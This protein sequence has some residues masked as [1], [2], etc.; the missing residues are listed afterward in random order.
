MSAQ[1]MTHVISN[2]FLPMTSHERDIQVPPTCSASDPAAAVI[3]PLSLPHP[4]SG[5]F[6]HLHA[7]ATHAQSPA[8]PGPHSETSKPGNRVYSPLSPGARGPL[9]YGPSYPQ[10]RV[11]S[12]TSPVTSAS[13][14]PSQGHGS[15]NGRSASATLAFTG[16][17]PP[18]PAQSDTFGALSHEQIVQ[19]LQ[20]QNAKI[21]EAWEAERK[22]LEANRERAEEVYKEER[23]LMEEERAQWEAERTA[24]IEEIKRLRQALKMAEARSVPPARNMQPATLDPR[25]LSPASY[26]AAAAQRT[27]AFLANGA[28]TRLPKPQY[29]DLASPRS[30][31]GPAA[32]V[33]DFLKPAGTPSGPVPVVD[34]KEIHPDLEG[35]P[36]K[37]TSVKK[38]TFTDSGSSNG[39]RTSSN[40]GSPSSNAERKKA[41]TQE[42]LAAQETERLTMHAGHTPS[43]SLS[44]LQTASSSGTNTP[45][46]G[47]K[48]PTVAQDEPRDCSK[49]AQE[50]ETA[51]APNEQAPP[52][53]DHPEPVLEPS[54]GDREL[55]G[56][57]MVRNMPAHDEIFFQALNSKLEEVSKDRNAAVPTVLA[58]TV[59]SRSRQHDGASGSDLG[60]DGRSTPRSGD[61]E[62]L[63]VPIKFRRRLNFGA[64]FGEIR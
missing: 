42:V 16:H 26:A 27:A 10:V 6:G 59:R 46:G 18:P 17:P 49:D 57:L 60:S 48:T 38:A 15:T 40:S 20:Q 41:Q 51:P 31:N 39:T 4:V 55:K 54:D 19:R 14:P 64:P 33:S 47:S 44:T 37:A 32:P 13:G 29:L 5:Y 11:S 22:Y 12:I 56:P 43:H 61:E 28:P 1:T 52:A 9:P 25:V 34:V 21:R 3:S 45:D 30:P 7:G 35:I 8:G 2:S 23:A 58:S 53:E 62:E 63:D 36:L 24:L 50:P